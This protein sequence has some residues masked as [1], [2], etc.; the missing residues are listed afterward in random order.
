MYTQGEIPHLALNEHCGA[1]DAL[2]DAAIQRPW[3]LKLAKQ[4]TSNP[5]M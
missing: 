4:R 3:R 5:V 1:L 2:V